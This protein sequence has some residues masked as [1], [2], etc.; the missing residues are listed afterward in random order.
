MTNSAIDDNFFRVR[1][2][3]R[4]KAKSMDHSV[5]LCKMK[6]DKNTQWRGRT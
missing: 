6:K 2:K 3:K 4:F 5:K 1:D